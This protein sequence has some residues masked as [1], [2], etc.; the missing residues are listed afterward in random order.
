[1]AVAAAAASQ[2]VLLQSA[3]VLDKMV[4]EMVAIRALAEGMAT[5]TL[6]AVVLTV[7][8]WTARR[9]AVALV[10]RQG[11]RKEAMSVR[12]AEERKAKVMMVAVA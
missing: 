5:R 8:V 3:M 2:R 4:V 11:I 10:R 12:E 6:V 9:A 1:M 7:S